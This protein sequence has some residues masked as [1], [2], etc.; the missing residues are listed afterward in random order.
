M[1]KRYVV[2]TEWNN[3]EPE[4][5]GPFW[6]GQAYETKKSIKLTWSEW[7]WNHSTGINV[8]KMQEGQTK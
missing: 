7:D 1:N 8:I 2:V 5:H 6:E 3:T 4:V